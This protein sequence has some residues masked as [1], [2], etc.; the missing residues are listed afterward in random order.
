MAAM[1]RGPRRLDESLA[2]VVDQR[3]PRTL[4]ADAQRAW[5]EACGEAIAASSEPVSERDGRITIACRTGAWA[6]ELELM[7]DTLT[8]RLESFLGT[9]RI[10][11]LRFTADLDRYR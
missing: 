9:D 3:A 4:L 11:A 10:A 5:P 7:Q 2:R 8:E 6:Q 1:D